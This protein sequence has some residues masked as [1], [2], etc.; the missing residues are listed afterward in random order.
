LV[1][2]PDVGVPKIG[3]IRVGVLASTFSPVPVE[4][5]TP[6]PP[7]A[8]GRIPV[9]PVVNGKPV[10]LVRTLPAAGVPKTGVISVGEVER[11]LAP[12]PVEVVTPVPPL[13]TDSGRVIPKVDRAAAAS[14]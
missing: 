7:F 5:V 9:T 6:V 8:T 3:V 12:L 1:S 13:A 11:T 14:D 2:V 10:Q 4:A